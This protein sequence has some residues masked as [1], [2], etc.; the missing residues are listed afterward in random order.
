MLIDQLEMLSSEYVK[1]LITDLESGITKN[2][3]KAEYT[4]RIYNIDTLKRILGDIK[5]LENNPV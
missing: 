3:S 5:R 2:Q 4:E 1:K